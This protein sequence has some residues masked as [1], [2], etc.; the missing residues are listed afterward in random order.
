MSSWQPSGHSW[1]ST[2]PPPP[3]RG[4]RARPGTQPPQGP[5]RG[6]GG[7]RGGG[8]HGSSVLRRLL[9]STEQP[10]RRGG[11]RT[12]G[13]RWL[14]GRAGVPT[15][16]LP[17]T[18]LCQPCSHGN[19][20]ISTPNS[21]PF[22][23]AFTNKRLL[24]PNRSPDRLERANFLPISAKSCEHVRPRCSLPPANNGGREAHS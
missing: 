6:G 9:S 17:R 19:C 3:L 5:Q 4:D 24:A 12:E 11:T 8:A 2:R 18:N 13:D 1:A 22:G 20:T 7:G 23:K 15:Q 21:F 16:L 10:D 14:W